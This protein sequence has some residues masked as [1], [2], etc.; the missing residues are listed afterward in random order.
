LPSTAAFAIGPHLHHRI[1]RARHRALDQQQVALGVDIG[2]LQALLGDPLVAHLA[3]HPH[4]FEDAGGEGAG[5]DRP[6]GAD[7]VGAVADRPATEV[8]ALD[9]A[10]EALADRDPRDLHLLAGLE[11]G[12][13]HVV[14][15]FDRV[16]SAEVLVAE[17]DQVAHRR[18]PG[19]LGV[20]LLGSGKL[21]RLDLAEG[22]LH[23]RVAVP[24]GL[25][26]RGHLAGAGLDHGDRDDGAV[27][28][29]D[30]RHAELLANDRGHR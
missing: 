5:A 20:A 4:P 13:R 28:A 11:G 7:V 3:R 14:A 24:L 27:L 2:D 1:A 10:L 15:Y 21:A 30:L 25:A 23:G 22:E 12:D 16:I 9:P 18:R 17:L 26:D 6:R 19:L 8:V 29:E